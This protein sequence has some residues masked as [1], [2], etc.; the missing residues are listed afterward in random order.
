MNPGKRKRYT[1]HEGPIEKEYIAQTLDTIIGGNAKFNRIS[2]LP[3]FEL[4]TEWKLVKYWL[5]D[6]YCDK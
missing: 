1:P 6:K 3:T 2:D 5:S 4:R